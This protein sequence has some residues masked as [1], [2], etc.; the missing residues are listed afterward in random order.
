MKIRPVVLL[1]LLS[2]LL[3]L[4]ACTGATA[5]DP[6]NP[7]AP[8]STPA[9][10]GWI[11]PGMAV[12]YVPNPAVNAGKAP[13]VAVDFKTAQSGAMVVLTS[14]GG[15]I[16]V[17]Q[18]TAIDPRMG[19]QTP[20][21]LYAARLQADGTVA[22]EHRYDEAALSGYPVALCQYSDD[23]C[24]VAVRN[25]GSS[26]ETSANGDMLLRIAPDGTLLWKVAMETGGAIE[27]VF[28]ASDGAILAAGTVARTGKDG[29]F[30]SDAHLWRFES[31]AR[32]SKEASV[33]SKGYDRLVDASYESGCGLV[34]L[35]ESD[36]AGKRTGSVTGLS[37]NIAC[38]DEALARKWADEAPEG[39]RFD[40]VVALK[41]GSFVLGTANATN[42]IDVGMTSRSMLRML[43]R[44]GT[45]VWTYI[46][47]RKSVWFTAAAPLNDGRIALCET[48]FAESGEQISTFVV[49]DFAGKPAV[50]PDP[51]YGIAQQIVGTKDGG[52]TAI[53]RQSVK[54]IPQPP[55]ISSIWTDTE[56]VIVHFGA[57]LRVM[58]LRTIDQYKNALRVDLVIPTINDCLFVD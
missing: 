41:G 1:L 51:V 27:R 6:F 50:Y 22:W 13:L 47:D 54:T 26:A 37:S 2:L 4:C 31:N 5:T 49:L 40:T 44:N 12:K 52:F 17:A 56:S 21:P 55:Y 33:G 30:E 15:C 36:N 24:V 35:F 25:A 23:G 32:L 18:N 46:S 39:E 9:P 7:P 28:T 48:R 45:T 19:S 16:S 43:D 3:C 11:S 42:P 34:L 38:Y 29:I 58:W 10:S 20:G 57:D 8:L 14:D 53:L